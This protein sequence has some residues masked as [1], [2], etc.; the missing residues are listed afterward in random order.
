MD[1]DGLFCKVDDF[2]K[3]FEATYKTQLLSSGQSKRNR[4]LSL[5]I[6]EMMSIILL[7][8]QSCYRH[9]K[10]FYTRFVTEQMRTYFPTLIS[11][12]RFIQLMPRVMVYLIAF[13]NSIR[14]KTTGISYV[15]STTISVCKNKRIKQHKVF[16]GIATRGKS[17]MGWFY[18]FKLHIIVNDNGELL[19][20][21]LTQG[22][23]DD[24]KP[25]PYLCTHLFG[26]LFADKGYISQSLTESLLKK[27]TR[28]FT[29]VRSNMKNKL[30]PLFD[31]ILLRKRFI[32]E[33]INDQLK[34]IS[35]IE[36]SR[37]RSP[38]NFIVNLV[39]GLISYQLQPKK[40]SLN[41]CQ[42]ELALFS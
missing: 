38:L 19:A 21:K 11:Y 31:R 24:R 39:A 10:G 15:D 27:G 13:L 16:R 30:L 8:Q 26:K 7:F 3:D 42:T 22:H 34:N 23:I 35:Q 12:S 1:V 6:S 36:H 25:V 4:N 37:H 18:G 20:W 32:I 28:L 17:S 14:G 33:T 29:S 5:S 2:C 9:F 41:L 40:P